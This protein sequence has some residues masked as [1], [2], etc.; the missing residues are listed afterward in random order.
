MEDDDGFRLR[1]EESEEDEI[2]FDFLALEIQQFNICEEPI[3][4]ARSIQAKEIPLFFEKCN[5]N[6]P[7]NAMDEDRWTTPVKIRTQ[8]EIDS[9]LEKIQM[10][11]RKK[12]CNK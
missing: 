4:S 12:L 5:A 7:P 8:A 9:R 3:Y 11:P 10:A 2:A 1:L 6:S